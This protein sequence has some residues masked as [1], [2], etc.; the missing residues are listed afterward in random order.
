M[1]RI[2]VNYFSPFDVYTSDFHPYVLFVQ[3]LDRVLIL[4]ITPKGPIKL[5]EIKSPATQEP[6]FYKWKMGIARGELIL[7]N[8]PNTIEEH[9]LDEIYILRDAPMTKVYPTFGYVIPDKFDLDFSDTG[10]LIYIQ[11]LDP[12]LP[13]GT[14]SVILVYK[15]GLPAVSAFYDVFHLYQRHDDLLIDVT[16]NFGD[17][18]A[19]AFGSVLMMYRQYEIPILVF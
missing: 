18:V 13:V 2:G 19:V 15:T 12:K 9:D 10:N 16:G 7:V 1:S 4:D 8:P 6:G 17:Y 5:A 14:N 3:C 11:A